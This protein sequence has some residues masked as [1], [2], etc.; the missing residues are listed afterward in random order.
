MKSIGINLLLGGTFL[1]LAAWPRIWY[2][3]CLRISEHALRAGRCMLE[4]RG[5]ERGP[6]LV[7]NERSFGL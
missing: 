2:E 5:P 7:R 1:H 6:S 3:K 4:G